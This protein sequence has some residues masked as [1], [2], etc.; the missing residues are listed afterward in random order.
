MS[1]YFARLRRQCATP[2]RVSIPILS[3]AL[4]CT[5]A[6]FLFLLVGAALVNLLATGGDLTPPPSDIDA[7]K[8]WTGEPAIAGG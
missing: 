8:Q 7:I 6:V 2:A 1:S 5:A 4:I 3:S